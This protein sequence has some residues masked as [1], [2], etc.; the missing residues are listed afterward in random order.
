MAQNVSQRYVQQA[1]VAHA[2]HQQ[3]V[4]NVQMTAQIH[5]IMMVY[6]QGMQQAHGIV[7]KPWLRT[8]IPIT[9]GHVQTQHMLQSVIQTALQA[10]I[11]QTASAEVH[12]MQHAV[13]TSHQ[14]RVTSQ[15]YVEQSQRCVT[16]TMA[17]IV[18]ML[19]TTHG[20]QAI[21]QVQTNSDVMIQTMHVYRAMQITENKQQLLTQTLTEMDIVNMRAEQI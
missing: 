16:A 8:T 10:A 4:S 18:M 5:I 20:M 9:T 11:Q 2:P 1:H 13:Q 3:M 7:M 21:R 15:K 19:T 17:I 14:A 12:P 6:A